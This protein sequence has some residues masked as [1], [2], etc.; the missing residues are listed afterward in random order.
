MRQ[1]LNEILKH[2]PSEYRIRNFGV[3]ENETSKEDTGSMRNSEI[4][5]SDNSTSESDI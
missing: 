2:E 3:E 1:S 4:Q 5:K